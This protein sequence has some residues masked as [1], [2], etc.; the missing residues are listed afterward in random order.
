MYKTFL[1]ENLKGNGNIEDLGI[2]ER[3]VF[4][5]ILEKQVALV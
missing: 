3:A 1:L 5:W 4:N 2:E